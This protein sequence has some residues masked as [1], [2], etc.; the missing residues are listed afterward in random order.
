M[1]KLHCLLVGVLLL[2][3]EGLLA[4]TTEV[5]GKITDPT[6][7]PIPNATIRVKST[8]GASGTS[9]D[10]MG[11]FTLKVKSG[12]DLIISAIGYETKEVRVTGATLTVVLNTDSKSLSEVVVTGDGA[13]EVR[14]AGVG[15]LE[16]DTRRVDGLP[17]EDRR[18]RAAD[19]EGARRFGVA[20]RRQ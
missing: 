14:V 18:L 5:S 8:R 10:G 13:V 15:V 2:I 3:G 9:A 11:A 19:S 20:D 6:G 16:N 12:T 7:S 17:A 4:Q 1:R